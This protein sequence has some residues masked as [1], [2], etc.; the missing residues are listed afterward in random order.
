[1]LILTNLIN[2]FPMP[3]TGVF[4]NIPRLEC[5]SE[6]ACFEIQ[7]DYL[8]E[9]GYLS[10]TCSQYRETLLRPSL[11]QSLCTCPTLPGSK[12][13]HSDDDWAQIIKAKIVSALFPRHLIQCRLL[14][15]SVLSDLTECE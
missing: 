7:V 10:G 1:M 2:L 3:L 5:Y 13:K 14:I 11:R 8:V 4:A 12:A 15:G 6:F 9:F